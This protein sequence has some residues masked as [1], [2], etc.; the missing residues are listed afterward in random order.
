MI[1]KKK[2]EK[3]EKAL[4]LLGNNVELSRLTSH[5]RYPQQSK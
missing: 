2:K 1:R 5:H 3:V 4:Y